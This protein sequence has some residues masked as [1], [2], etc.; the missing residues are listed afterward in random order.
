MPHIFDNIKSFLLDD[1]TD[2]FDESY[3][4]DF[5]VGY[6]N[7]RG[8]NLLEQQIDQLT[9]G[10][11]ANC[12]LLVGMFRSPKESVKREFAATDGHDELTQ[13]EASA[14]RKQIVAEFREQLT[15]GVPTNQ[16]EQSLQ[17][18]K[19]QLEA[20]KLTVKLYLRHPL[21]AKLYLLHYKGVQP[22]IGY[23]GSSNLT[24]SGLRGNG[25]LNIDVRD[26]VASETLAEWFEDRWDDR[27]C[28]DITQELIDII[29][30]SWA[31][32]ERIPPYYIYLKMAYHLSREA[33][34]GIDEFSI[35][36]PFNKILFDFQKS[37][38]QI[39]ARHLNQR[40]GVLIGD[41]VG[42]GK[43]L[44]AT[45]LAK[46]FEEDLFLETLI[47]CPKNLERMW[48]YQ[49]ETYGLRARV[50]PISQVQQELGNLTR[51][52]LVLIDE[53]HNLRNRE[54]KRYAAIRD[55]ISRMESRVILLSA[56]P[57]NKSYLDLSNQLRL[58]ID[59][60]ADLGMRPE[61]LIREVGLIEF[62]RRY[63]NVPP[64]SLLAFEKSEYPDDW[65]ELMRLF[66]VRRTRSFIRDNYARE[67]ER[68]RYL[69]YADGQRSYFPTR[70]PRRLD[71]TESKQF[72]RL[73]REDVVDT[74]NELRLPRYGLG[75]Y[76]KKR[77]TTPPTPHEQHI[78]DNLSRAGERLK[79]FSRTNLF[80]RLESSG[81]AFL[82]SIER[83]IL[84]NY[85]FLHALE[86]GL[87]LPIGTQ[88][89]SVLDTTISDR[90]DEDDDLIETELAQFEP[91]T[92]QARAAAIYET[93]QRQFSGRF[94][95]LRPDLFKRTLKSDLRRDAE[96]LLIILMEVGAW[97]AADDA[98]LRALHE[99]LV[100]QHPNDKVLVFSQ[101]ADTVQYLGNALAER[102]VDAEPVTGQH[103]D[104]TYAAWRFSPHSNGKRHA[105]APEDELRVLIATDVLSEGQN[106]Q[107]AF[108]V[109]NYDLPWAIIRLI[110]RAGRVDRIGQRS[111]EIFVYS[112]WPAEGIERLIRLRSRLRQRLAENAAVVGADELFFEDEDQHEPE[113]L[114]ALY[115][116]QSGILDDDEDREVD[117]VSYAYQI[118]KNATDAN[119]ALKPLIERMP[120]VVYS[121]KHAGQEGEMDINR[122]GAQD[123]VLIFLRS[124]L[125]TNALAWVDG[126]GNSVTQSQFDILQAASCALDEL[127]VERLQ[128]HH[129]LVQAAV[130]TIM[131]EQQAAGVQL[132]RA[133][134]ARFQTYERMKNYILQYEGTLFSDT[135][136]QQTLKQAVELMGQYRLRETATNLLNRQLRSGIKNDQLARVVV[137][138]FE[139]QK[140]CIVH[141]DTA[142]DEPQ[143]ICSLGLVRS[144]E[145]ECSESEGKEPEQNERK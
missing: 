108:V 70:H 55:Y 101:F 38:V 129:E 31:R 91:A 56:T 80:K 61:Q 111:D 114:R 107:D 39:A 43:T 139:E 90:G 86:N 121:A 28:I 51:Y 106:L 84:R 127:A 34:R 135:P 126:A 141:D 66:M 62:N 44:M 132:G 12:R 131:S 29:E 24:F 145:S 23:L 14:R 6:F 85:V 5:C 128:N 65:R 54:G 32:T 13:G 27:L 52:R 67:D 104:P 76:E 110:Q 19:A 17:R 72:Q 21:H 125:G 112:M 94:Q 15:F 30:E 49:V 74:I 133:S 37:A 9:G 140:L 45:A 11:G 7:L 57:Y 105:I 69:E 47:I 64:R 87:P 20:G 92:F 138:L 81:H 22:R 48:L 118:W 33:Q 58:F 16:S 77:H 3:R 10:E 123:G 122:S 83:H 1:L 134:G 143:I 73:Y 50:L 40:G 99:L 116:E 4:V 60:E 117:L 41:V 130:Q 53:S 59:A 109:I 113:A 96:N 102:G 124:A 42:L 46:L 18:L 35:P 75:Q 36:A 8:W 97:D 120:D 115:D 79:G 136:E 142:Q 137:T 63:E 95:W 103:P 100:D 98:K 25:E 119:P 78:L 144:S 88:D 82:L 68:G 26:T 71:Y 89:L 93:Y 2:K